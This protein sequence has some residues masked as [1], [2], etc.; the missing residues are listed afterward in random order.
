M[1]K[2]IIFDL[3]D[4]LLMTKETKYQALK[5]AG[6]HFYNIEISDKTIDTHWG[7]PFLEFMGEVFGHAD[8]SENISKNY[9]SI[10]KKYKNKPYENTLSTL[11]K[12]FGNYKI[13]ILSSAAQSLVMYDIECA[14]LPV[15]KFTYIQSAEDTNVHKP[16]PKVFEP[17]L[18]VMSEHGIQPS[19]MLYL[20]DTTY[21]FEA[22]TGAGLS[23]IGMANRTISKSDF[24]KLGTRSIE[25]ISELPKLLAMEFSHE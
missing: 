4:T 3:D 5:F 15:E 11:E 8:E 9:K 22:A 13:G 14:G 25:S 6:K 16:N 10:V 21:D 20:G 19:D 7:K 1:I 24:D 18:R 2:A 23:F 12:L 17:I